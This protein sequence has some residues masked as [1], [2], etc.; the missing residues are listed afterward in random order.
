MLL[1]VINLKKIYTTRFGANQVQAL[2]NVSFRRGGRIHRHHGRI[3]LR[4]DDAFEYLASLDKPTSG[5]VVLNGTSILS[6]GEKK[7][8]LSAGTISASFS[9][10]STPGHIF[11]A[12]Q[13]FLPLVLAGR[14]YSEMEARLLP[15]A[16]DSA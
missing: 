16:K 1:E 8:R 12:G 6:I 15:I 10:I 13:Y 5:D 9:R 7:S 2:A 4:Q 11:G 3:G 14:R